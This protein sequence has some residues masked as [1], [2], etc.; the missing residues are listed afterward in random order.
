MIFDGVATEGM[1]LQ[2]IIPYAPEGEDLV[3]DMFTL[4]TFNSGAGM[5]DQW[6]YYVKDGDMEAPE[7]GWYIPFETEE[8]AEYTFEAGEGF[9]F[10]SQYNDIDQYED[11]KSAGVSFKAVI[12]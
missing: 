12:D 2:D 10:E 11:G 7:N 9:M 4:Q 6:V 8:K 5:V 1:S 3:D